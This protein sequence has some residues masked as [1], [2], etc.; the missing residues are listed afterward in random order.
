MKFNSRVIL[1]A[2]MSLLCFAYAK[3]QDFQVKGK[4]IDSENTPLES[5]TIHIEKVQ[6][7]SLVDYTI[8]DVDGNFS[9]EG[10][11][12]AN[13]INIF[14]SYTG[15]NTYKKQFSLQEES[16]IDLGEVIMKFSTNSLEEVLVKGNRAPVTIKK[17]TLEFN[18]ASFKT[19]PNANV[20][21]V[22]KQLP[23]VEVDNSGKITVNGKEVSRILVNGKE[24]F[25]DDPKIATKNLPKEIIDKIQVV[26]TKT[27]SEEF[28][29]EEGDSENKT[30]N[31]TV[32]EDK[33]KGYFSRLTAGGGTD[34]RYELSGI[35]NYFKDELR[36]SVLGSS[37]NINSSGFTFDEVFDAMGRSAYS[38]NGNGGGGIT[39]ADNAGFNFANQWGEKADLNS[40]YFFNRTDNKTATKVERENILP[41]RTYFNNSESTSNRQN[42]NHRARVNFE[43]KPDSLTRISFRPNVNMNKGFSTSNSFT[44][45]FENDGTPINNATTQKKGEVFNAN[46]SNRFDITRKFGDKGA[47]VRLGL[48]TT[49]ATS[50]DDQVYYSSR[51]IY[52]DS[53]NLESTEV[54]DQFIDQDTEEDEY[55]LEFRSRLPLSG[56][57]SLDLGYSYRK[58]NQSSARLVYDRE[59]G[60]EVFNLLNNEL[61]NDFESETFNHRPE[62]GLVFN[63]DKIRANFSGGLQNIRL[64]NKDLFTESSFD[65][66][67]TNLFVNANARYK[68]TKTKS[69]Y[70]N[71]R[72]S[73]NTPSLTQLQP[74]TNTTNPLN[75]VTGNP[76]LEPTLEHSVYANFNNYDFKSRSG[77]YAYLGGSLYKDRVVSFT[78][79]N[80]DLV[81]TTTYTNV[82]GAYSA[83]AGFSL[84]KNIEL[85][86]G[87]SLNPRV[88]FRTT[89]NRNVGFSNTQKYNSETLSL[90]PQLAIR[91]EIEEFLT[92]DPNYQ[93]T[94][95]NASYSL[96]ANRNQN[97]INHKLGIEVT[98]YWPKNFIFGNDIS[99]QHMGNM[100]PGF[101]ND[102]VLWNMSLGYQ[103]LGDDGIVKVKVFDVLDQNI[104]T[105]RNTGED[106]IQD[107]QQLVLEQYV[108][109]SFTYKFSKFGGKKPNDKRGRF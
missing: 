43:F 69:V 66:T 56:Q 29:G 79:T 58:S 59:E 102:F 99:Y 103:L 83:F 49:N 12:D 16:N 84:N 63:S 89:F 10:K 80:E 47:F 53:G 18:A 9:V 27:K 40:N 22:L 34:E 96:D 7:S 4:V 37:N 105:S 44:E 108:M 25:G 93:L 72:S 81:R 5:A 26:D 13:A 50:E 45:S 55:A 104:A 71:Y 70:F 15:F 14:I 6:D 32:K 60:E 90:S 92:L 39:K 28:T 20:E 87:N 91:Y 106:F 73:R 100:A 11:S 51:E 61:S 67:Y 78:T 23:G 42:D 19:Q 2:L 109:F 75:I 24:F 65:N 8:S 38:I 1:L 54:Q 46:F 48:N 94:Y 21:D 30:I 52:N 36:L 97:Y 101:K 98:S 86:N 82:N 31:L 77:F 74:V 41:D 88:G 68:L 57:V 33:N 17:D 76:D 95:N 62:L 35:A 85:E 3:A 64:K 107:T